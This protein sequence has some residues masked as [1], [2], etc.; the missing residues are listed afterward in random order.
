MCDVWCACKIMGSVCFFLLQCLPGPG[1]TQRQTGWRII[2]KTKKP[3]T[4][5]GEPDG[6]RCSFHATKDAFASR[7]MKTNTSADCR[8]PHDGCNPKNFNRR[9]DRLH[10]HR[11]RHRRRWFLLGITGP[12]GCGKSTL[13][14]QL[15]K[16]LAVSHHP[17]QI[18]SEDPRFFRSPAAASYQNRD[19]I[20]ETP[21]HVDWDAYRQHLSSILFLEE[22]EEEEEEDDEY[23]PGSKDSSS[24]S[25]VTILLVEHFLLLHDPWVKSQLDGLVVL[26]GTMDVCLQRRIRRNPHRSSEEKYFLSRYYQDHVWPN[27]QRYCQASSSQYCSEY[28][29]SSLQV[30]SL[31][32]IEAI[33]ETVFRVVVQTWI[34]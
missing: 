26:T 28:P 2:A 15:S 5:Y 19:P 27:Y 18:V 22:E 30:S 13:A 21:A 14:E 16:K 10:R 12:S 7:I 24:S 4:K 1:T 32:P 6:S 34:G 33:V 20:S 11:Q 8:Q 25:P 23:D 17:A 9:L 29:E 3:K 31:D